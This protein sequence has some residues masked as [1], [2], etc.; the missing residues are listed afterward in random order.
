MKSSD[1]VDSV[2]N[3]Q[4]GLLLM[5]AF[6]MGGRFADPDSLVLPLLLVVLPWLTSWGP[7]LLAEGSVPNLRIEQKTSVM[8]EAASE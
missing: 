4:N 3:A 5:A 2:L 8:G 6:S 1:G 7:E